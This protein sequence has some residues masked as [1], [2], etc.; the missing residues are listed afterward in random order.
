[1][2]VNSL[3]VEAIYRKLLDTADETARE[4][5]FKDRLIT[6][7]EGLVN[8]FG[9]DGLSAYQMWG[10]TPRQFAPEN[11]AHTLA[12]ID[13]L[14]A[15]NAWGRAESALQRGIAAWADYA[16]RLADRSI[17]F[18]LLY[19]QTQMPDD[20]GYSGFGAIPGWIMVTYSQPTPYTLARVEA[21]TIHELHHNL[22]ATLAPGNL[23]VGTA[24]VGQYMIGEGLAESFARE[25]YGEDVI[26]PW[27]TGF[28]ISRMEHTK[29]VFREGLNRTGF[30]IT[31]QYIFGGKIAAAGRPA[32]EVPR[33]AGYAL[34][35]HVVQHYLKR[36]G[37]SVVEA[38]FVSADELIAV[39][40]F[41]D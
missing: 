2:Q 9:G 16:D 6:P 11:R 36:T 7:F 13:A 21:A 12:A 35:Y 31:R 28:D 24:S 15:A 32:V 29:R 41:F 14:S 22:S 8:V 5:I 33:F 30:G 25:L 10:M 18:A 3:D 26:G 17:T 1:M 20:P 40:G 39:S 19:N 23:D 27:A 34:G 4:Q 37:K 38:T